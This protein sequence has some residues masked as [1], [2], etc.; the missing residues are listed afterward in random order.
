M[1]PWPSLVADTCVVPS[2]YLFKEPSPQRPWTRHNFSAAHAAQLEMTDG[3]DVV[4]SSHYDRSAV[5][6]LGDEHLLDLQAIVKD[7][8]ASR[9]VRARAMLAAAGEAPKKRTRRLKPLAK[10]ETDS[11][12]VH[13]EG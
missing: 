12:T 8:V 7:E 3:K 6:A 1:S 5:S 2:A 11:Y 10:V 4:N 13:D 9:A